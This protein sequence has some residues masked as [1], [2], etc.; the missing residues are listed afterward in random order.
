MIKV[1]GHQWWW[2]VQ[3]QDLD[4]SRMVDDRQRD[5]HPGRPPG[6]DPAVVRRRDPQ[7][8]GAEPARQEGPDPRPRRRDLDPGRPPRG[9]PRPVRRVLRLPAR[10][11]GASLVVAE[12]PDASAPGATPSAPARRRA[13]DPEPAARAAGLPEPAPARCATPSRGRTPAAQLGPDLTHL[14]SRRTHRRRRSLPNTRGNLGG[15]IVDPAEHQA[16]Q[17][18][19]AEQLDAGRPAGAARLPGESPS[20]RAEP[21]VDPRPTTSDPPGSGPPTARARPGSTP[22]GFWGWLT[23]GRP[24]GD[25]Q[26]LHRDRLRLLRCSAGIEALMMRLQLARP[27]NTFPRPRPLQPDLHHARHDDDVPLR[28]A[29]DGGARRSTSCR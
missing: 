8:L 25:R 2:E 3:Y 28:R 23:D 10:A 24:Q 26:A 16:R 12:P 29:G 13:G 18:H 21:S 11:H 9:L 5:P 17:P 14:A 20:E 27:E 1:T 22:P 19:A 7:L 6:A 4:P 15:W